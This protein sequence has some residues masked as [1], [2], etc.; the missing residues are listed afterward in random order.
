MPENPAKP[1][2]GPTYP[3]PDGAVPVED[4]V[5]AHP[6]A[7]P[8]TVNGTVLAVVH[9]APGRH[10]HW[11]STNLTGYGSILCY[12][13]AEAAAHWVFKQAIADEGRCPV[14]DCNRQAA[15]RPEWLHIE[16]TNTA[17]EVTWA[18]FPR[19][20][21]TATDGDHDRD[22]TPHAYL[23][24]I[25]ALRDEVRE[26]TEQR[27]TIWYRA[28]CRTCTT[29]PMWMPFRDRAARDQWTETHESTGH[30]VDRSE[31]TKPW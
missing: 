19:D 16:V 18:G 15:M 14:I 1:I 26:L 28:A 8:V 22:H 4:L 9:P 31:S 20:L 3:A 29:P 6:G 5:R 7:L 21:D 25:A 2:P 24:T 13:S 17:V 23:R 27:P 12:D 10:E 11:T 30:R